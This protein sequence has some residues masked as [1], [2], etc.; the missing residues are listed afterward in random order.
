MGYASG[1]RDAELAKRE[2]AWRSHESDAF[3]T[4]PQLHMLEGSVRVTPIRSEMDVPS[5]HFSR[6]IP[7]GKLL[8]SKEVHI[9][10]FGQSDE[11]VCWS[12]IGYASGYTSAFMG[13]F[14]LFKEVECVACGHNQCRIVG[15]PLE[16]WE[17]RRS[18]H[19]G[20]FQS[21]S[22]LNHLLELRGQVDYLRTTITQQTTDA[23][24]GRLTSKGF[25]HA[26][27]I[28]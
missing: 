14:I 3:V 5:G 13:R 28:W 4:G 25:K 9:R 26:Y 17:R 11:P 16:E 7:V 24:T 20:Y 18:E 10:E 8:G 23:A 19:A 15:K 12:Q 1:V 22:M 21:D 27:S 6:R 2:V